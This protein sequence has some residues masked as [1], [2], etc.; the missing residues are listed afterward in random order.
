[1]QLKDE[2]AEIGENA[3]DVLSWAMFLSCGT[4]GSDGNVSHVYDL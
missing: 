3:G 2:V 1:M 4:I